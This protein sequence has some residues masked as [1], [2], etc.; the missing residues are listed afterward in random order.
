LKKNILLRG[1]SGT[2]HAITL[3]YLITIIMSLIFLDG[4]YSPVVPALSEQF[5]H[6]IYAVLVQ[7]A[8]FALVGFVQGAASLIWDVDEWGYMKQT[9]LFFFVCSITVLPVSYIMRWMP[10]T[11][12]GFIVFYSIF[13]AIFFV[14]WCIQFC[15]WKAKIKKIDDELMKHK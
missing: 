7:T 6:E 13:T 8:F 5:E 15:I 3:G 4:Q 1:W 10:R 11:F 12:V 9:G 14:V 2:I